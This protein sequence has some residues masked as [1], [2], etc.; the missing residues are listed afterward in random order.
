MYRTLTLLGLPPTK[1]SIHHLAKCAS[2]FSSTE[3]AAI[4]SH[5][6][7]RIIV[8]D[9]GSQGGVSLANKTNQIGQEVKL[10][11][12]DHHYSKV[13]P[14][15]ALTVSACESPPIATSSILTYCLCRD[16][17]EK[18]T[19]KTDW[20]AIMGCFGDLGATAVKW[21][22][23]PWPAELGESVKIYTKKAITDSVSMINAPRRTAEFDGI[24]IH[25]LRVFVSLLTESAFTV[26]GA[27]SILEKASGP[28]EV[29]KSPLLR[30]ARDRVNLEVERRTHTPPKFSKDGRVALLRISSPYQGAVTY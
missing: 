28:M 8:L 22:D 25:L 7:T 4:D 17:H 15:D 11:V 20:L 9:Q 26:A 21:G 12:L 5:D 29:A 19:E 24:P 1:I 2:I 14:D 18:V 10:M 16:L 30:A 6:C 13:F 23:G 27:W 3:R